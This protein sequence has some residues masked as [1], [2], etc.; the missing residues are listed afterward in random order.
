MLPIYFAHSYRDE[1]RS[2][3]DY[4]LNLMQ[5]QRLAACVDVPS[6]RLNAAKQERQLGFASGLVAILTDRTTGPS[7]FILAEINMAVRVGKPVLVFCEETLPSRLLPERVLRDRYSRRSY[8][9]S[10]RD[11]LDA[12][13]RLKS[14][15]GDVLLP[16]LRNA[17]QQRTACLIGFEPLK[18]DVR[19]A[20]VETV[21]RR[22]Y[23]PLLLGGSST[24]EWGT[25]DAASALRDCHLVIGLIDRPTPG[26][27]YW[28]GFARAAGV[29]TLLV[30]ITNSPAL[31]FKLP[32][33]LGPRFIAADDPE[34]ISDA[35][36]HEIDVFEDEAFE[37]DRNDEIAAYIGYLKEAART[38]GSYAADLRNV[39]IQNNRDVYNVGEAGA[40][41][42]GA[43]NRA[44]SQ[45]NK[46]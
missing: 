29:P 11:H 22:N 33:E 14:Q 45:E 20:F 13:Q 37:I 24:A 1:D 4:F 2:L 30:N 6:N 38:P 19:S 17:D 32:A 21:K 43:S 10:T 7:P 41:G 18:E 31:S 36:S 44:S 34:T 42:P 46:G 28:L 39:F 15:I 9:R 35:L 12:V 8:W 40:A 23:Q 25:T 27:A 16:R 26:E 5:D 3:N